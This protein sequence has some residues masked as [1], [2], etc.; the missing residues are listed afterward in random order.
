MTIAHSQGNLKGS[1][2]RRLKE[3]LKETVI[4]NDDCFFSSK[5]R[6]T[7]TIY[8]ILNQIATFPELTKNAF[9]WGER[10]MILKIL[11]ILRLPTNSI[12]N[13]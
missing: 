9:N 5:R 2:K 8:N 4:D 11:N 13:E 12:V 6:L 1:L 7:W 3:D 10:M